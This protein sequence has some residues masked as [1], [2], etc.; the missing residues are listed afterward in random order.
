MQAI[1]LLKQEEIKQPMP[2]TSVST[3]AIS[4]PVSRRSIPTSLRRSNSQTNTKTTSITSSEDSALY[5]FPRKAPL[6]P[7]DHLSPPSR[8]IS[9][10]SLNSS[11]ISRSN[12]F[13]TISSGASSTFKSRELSPDPHKQHQG[14]QSPRRVL[15]QKSQRTFESDQSTVHSNNKPDWMIMAEANNTVHP[16]NTPTTSTSTPKQPM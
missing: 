1:T 2:N 13:N 15:S 14:F 7:N 12:T 11:N 16:L 5:Q 9:P 4:R 10:Q 3:S 8:P 6:P